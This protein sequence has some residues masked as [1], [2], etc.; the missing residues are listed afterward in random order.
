MEPTTGF[1]PVTSS[2]PKTRSTPELRGLALVGGAGF[3]P[4][5]ASATRFTVWPLWPLGHP[6]ALGNYTR[7]AVGCVK[8]D[9]G[10]SKIPLG[11]GILFL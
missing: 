11:S 1:E 6:P 2:L 8:G 9:G 3:E 5:K 10:C 4:A 7:S